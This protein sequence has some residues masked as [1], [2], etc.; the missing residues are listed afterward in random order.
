M[1]RSGVRDGRHRGAVLLFFVIVCIPII[2]IALM[3]AVDI[4]RI[5]LAHRQV[6]NVAQAAALAGAWQLEPGTTTV[7][8]TIAAREMT[9]LVKYSTSQGSTSLA[10]GVQMVGASSDGRLTTGVEHAAASAGGADRVTAVLSFEVPDLLFYPVLVRLFGS[11]P[12][13]VIFDASSSASVCIP[14]AEGSQNTGGVCA[15]PVS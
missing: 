2:M 9:D 10:S 3:L 12:Q 14:G 4:S 6:G 5:Y 8:D 13:T 15:H 7:S 1:S 11:S